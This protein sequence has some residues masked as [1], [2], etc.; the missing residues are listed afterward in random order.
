MKKLI[1]KYYPVFINI[2][3]VWI[4]YML[5]FAYNR[6][7]IQL[8]N[9]DIH[10]YPFQ[11][12]KQMLYTYYNWDIFKNIAGNIVCFIPYGFLGLLYP[13]LKNYGWLFLTFFISINFLEFSQYF[14]QRGFAEIDDVILNTFGMTIGFILYKRIFKI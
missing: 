7:D 8:G 11:S 3:T 6:S 4:L 9:F 1:A 10:P 13:K 12:I 2:Y 14:F 5:F